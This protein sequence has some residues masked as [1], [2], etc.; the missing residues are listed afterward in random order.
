MYRLL[1]RATAYLH[2]L[3]AE[4]LFQPNLQKTKGEPDSP[5]GRA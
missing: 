1:K 3:K 4:Q 5:D 2:I